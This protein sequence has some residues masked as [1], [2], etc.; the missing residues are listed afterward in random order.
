MGSCG[1]DAQ[2]AVSTVFNRAV[3]CLVTQGCIAGKGGYIFSLTTHLRNTSIT[4]I[5]PSQLHCQM[6][7]QH[8]SHQD[9]TSRP[10][11]CS[12]FDSTQHLLLTPLN[13]KSCC[14]PQCSCKSELLRNPFPP[15]QDSKEENCFLDDHSRTGTMPGLVEQTSSHD[16][17][18]AASASNTNWRSC[19]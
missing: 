11:G 3:V 16:R 9:K 5:T 14:V 12:A 1:G 19:Y 4:I 10:A 15:A 13:I 6:Q 7:C 2:L 18:H 8:S 17:S